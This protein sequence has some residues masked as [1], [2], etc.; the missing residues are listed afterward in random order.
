MTVEC[1]ELRCGLQPDGAIF[2]QRLQTQVEIRR[3]ASEVH[4]PADPVQQT[5]YGLGII[6]HVHS[7]TERSKSLRRR[8]AHTR[9][10]TYFTQVAFRHVGNDDFHRDHRY[11]FVHRPD[12]SLHT[13]HVTL[14]SRKDQCVQIGEDLDSDSLFQRLRNEFFECRYGP[15]RQRNHRR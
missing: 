5:V 3:D 2:L 9:S 8:F 13:G 12:E 10:E 4:R 1:R 7:R 11:G 15:E 14:V 6:S